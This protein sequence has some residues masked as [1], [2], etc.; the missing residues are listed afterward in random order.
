MLRGRPRGSV[1]VRRQPV[2]GRRRAVDSCRQPVASSCQAPS[3]RNVQDCARAEDTAAVEG[4]ALKQP[5][6]KGSGRK[7]SSHSTKRPPVRGKVR[8]SRQRRRKPETEATSSVDSLAAMAGRIAELQKTARGL[9]IFVDDR[10]L[11]ACSKCGLMEDVLFDG[12]LVTCREA[13]GTDTALRF[14]EHPRA[15]GR[16]VCPGCGTVLP[17]RHRS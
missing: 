2:D 12:R 6:H 1:K 7:L 5:T 8:A 13:D 4:K 11:L 3:G 15:E 10:E 17:S 14:A 16:F 9:G